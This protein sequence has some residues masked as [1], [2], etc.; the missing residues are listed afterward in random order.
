[1]DLSSLCT[2]LFVMLISGDLGEAHFIRMSPRSSHVKKELGSVMV[3]CC[4]NWSGFL[5]QTSVLIHCNCL[6]LLIWWNSTSSLLFYLLPQ[7]WLT[8]LRSSCSLNFHCS[9]II[10]LWFWSVPSIE[11]KYVARDCSYTTTDTSFPC[12]HNYY[13][14]KMKQ[15]P[16]SLST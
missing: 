8:D 7:G 12:N 1:M 2:P 15:L 3:L 13:D 16:W 5:C 11:V 9:D 10:F 6:S 14:C 4:L